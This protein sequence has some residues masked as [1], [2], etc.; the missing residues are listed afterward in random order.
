M[1]GGEELGGIASWPDGAEDSPSISVDLD[2]KTPIVEM[3]LGWPIHRLPRGKS[4]PCLR[5]GTMVGSVTLGVFGLQRR[6][7]K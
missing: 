4:T 5:K 3:G 2:R 1:Q 6:P 7:P